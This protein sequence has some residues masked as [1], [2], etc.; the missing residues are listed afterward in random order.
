VFA[1][2]HGGTK[3]AVFGVR[4]LTVGATLIISGIL[5]RI[6]RKCSSV[7]ATLGIADQLFGMNKPLPSGSKK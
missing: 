5:G 2:T 4:G 7:R 1:F 6:S 3:P